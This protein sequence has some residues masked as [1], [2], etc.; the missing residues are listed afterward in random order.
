MLVD[1]L[2]SEL[3]KRCRKNPNY[4]LRAFARALN[5]HSSTLSAVLNNKR[6]LSPKL[7]KKILDDLGTDGLLKQKIIS[8]MV[9]LDEASNESPEFVPINSD[10]FAIISDWEHF[11][12]LALL[13]TYDCKHTV[14]W[15]SNR[16]NIGTGTVLLALSRLERCGLLKRS[17]KKWLT[18][19]KSFATSS[20]IPDAAIR[21]NNRQYMEKAIYSLENHPV[22]DRDI[23][24]IT[25]AIDKSKLPEAK[26]LIRNFRRQ[27]SKFLE[28]GDQNDVY[29][30]NI[31]LFPLDKI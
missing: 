13:E 10:E 23:T 15:I 14:N 22:S 29:R 30:I 4:S 11:A 8:S 25:M 18:T 6:K 21:K 31:Q 20:E 28:A 16:L 5:V 9:G 27:L 17:N 3:S 19:G 1:Y 24:G 7:A 12:I 26:T 2:R